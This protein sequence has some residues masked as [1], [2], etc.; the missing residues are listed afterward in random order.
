MKMQLNFS[1]PVSRALSEL[2]FTELTEVQKQAI[3][4]ILQGEDLIA[5][6]RTGTGKTAAFA[7]PLLEH[8]TSKPPQNHVQVL[9]LVP[10]RELAL[11]VGTD[12]K[13]IG[14]NTRL[15]FL[16]AYGGTGIE[17]QIDM[18]RSGVQIVVGT[19]GRIIDLIEHNALDLSR[20]QTFVLDEAD[21]MLAM[22]FVRDV[23]KI[24]SF[25]P[26]KKQVLLF[27]VDLPEEIMSLA[28]RHMRYPQHV[29]LVSSDKSAQGVKQVF[30]TV[31]AGRKL[32]GLIYLL[33]EL[34]PERALIFCRTKRRVSEL[35]RQLN[36]NG[37]KADGIQGNLTQAQRTHAME[38]F[39]AGHTN[40][41]VATDVASRGIH[42]EAISH[43]FNYELPYDINNYIH[44]I[45]RTGRMHAVGEAISLCYSDELGTLGQI[46]RLIGKTLE[47]KTLP[48]NLPAP[49]MPPFSEGSR[50]SSGP[51]RF[52]GGRPQGR[53]SFSRGRGG[54][55]RDRGGREPVRR[56]PSTPTR[57]TRIG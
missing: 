3:P 53:G 40:I 38:S 57:F 28:R 44:R 33:H 47:E 18:L 13:K 12:F 8:L 27:C 48:Q 50:R 5:Q 15:R 55:S 30:Y 54:Y 14:K 36:F 35:A 24:M 4:F 31:H 22:G 1:E 11:Q 41:L 26:Q 7:I 46:E 17:R 21:V 43:V 52:G 32:S 37:I 10:T 23:E 51:S 19:P 16:V 29:K 2:G 39:K 20:V 42:V 6:S 34:K 45:G 49:R 56:G 9:V 25:T